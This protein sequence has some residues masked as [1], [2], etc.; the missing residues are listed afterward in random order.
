MYISPENGYILH[1]QTLTSVAMGLAKQDHSDPND[2]K[3]DMTGFIEQELEKVIAQQKHLRE[4]NPIYQQMDRLI[5]LQKDEKENL[6]EALPMSDQETLYDY[7]QRLHARKTIRHEI[8]V[9]LQKQNPD[10][11]Y[12]DVE[13]FSEYS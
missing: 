13:L 9:A 7:R 3:N 4:S 5:S 1:S 10:S 11:H 8:R 12:K 6:L 2:L